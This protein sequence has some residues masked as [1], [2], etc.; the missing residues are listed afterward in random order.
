LPSIETPGSNR[1]A[2]S[3]SPDEAIGADAS[4]GHHDHRPFDHDGRPDDD[5]A[6]IGLASAI[7]TAMPA[8][9]A[10]ACG[11]GRAAE[12]CDRTGD[13]N[14]CDKVFHIVYFL[15]FLTARRHQSMAYPIRF[16]ASTTGDDI[17][18]FQAYG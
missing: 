12:A 17:E 5:N 2:A 4:A 14:C 18:W 9:T 15:P 13:Q 10:S 8:G 16:D 1:A 7:G 3:V 6:A 11:V